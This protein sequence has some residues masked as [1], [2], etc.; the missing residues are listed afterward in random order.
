MLNE[1]TV[2]K[3]KPPGC[4]RPDRREWGPERGPTGQG[5][6]PGGPVSAV[7]SPTA[8][9]AARGHTPYRAPWHFARNTTPEGSVQEMVR[10]PPS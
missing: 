5:R 9:L 4:S 10:G 1:P 7:Y 2:L 6:S 8:A 3:E